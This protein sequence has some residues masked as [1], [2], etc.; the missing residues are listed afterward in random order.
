M[1]MAGAGTGGSVGNDGGGSG[2]GPPGGDGAPDDG[3]ALPPIDPSTKLTDLTDAQKAELCDWMNAELGGY[4]LVT[5]CGGGNTTKNSS[6]QAQCV[7][8]ALTYRCPVTVGQLET[9]VE[10]EAPSHACQ[11]P[12][13]A[14]KAVGCQ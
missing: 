1:I 3:P 5:D 7:A 9:C 10:A 12:M 14:C 2:G 11:F 4:G 6:D 8:T 13:P